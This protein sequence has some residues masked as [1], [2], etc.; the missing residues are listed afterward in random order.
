[1]LTVHEVGESSDSIKVSKK[2]CR[3]CVYM[4]KYVMSSVNSIE[5]KRILIP[6]VLQF[7]CFFACSKIPII[8]LSAS[9]PLLKTHNSP[10][11]P[12]APAASF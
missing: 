1:M 7:Q 2:A 6:Y 8:I 9:S 4:Q 10:R 11:P 12:Q 3:K 5:R